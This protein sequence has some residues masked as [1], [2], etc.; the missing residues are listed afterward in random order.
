MVN[1]L[2][3][4]SK[5][6]AKLWKLTPGNILHF[7]K[8]GDNKISN[9]KKVA[10]RTAPCYLASLFLVCDCEQSLTAQ[11]ERNEEKTR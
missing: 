2:I 5:N 8:A 11:I 3:K 9:T 4:L 6:Q 1:L 7:L 10:F